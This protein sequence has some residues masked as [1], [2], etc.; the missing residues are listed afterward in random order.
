MFLLGMQQTIAKP[1]RVVGFGYWSGADVCVEFRPAPVDAGVTFVRSDLGPNARVA[2]RADLRT[3]V[4]RRT[5][6][7]CGDVQVDM[8]EHILAALAGMQVDNCE[9]WVD[10][11]EMPGCDGSAQVF[12]D[13]IRRVG[14]VR[15]GAT[16]RWLTIA[17]RIKLEEGECWI[18]ARPSRSN[19]LSIEFQLDYPRDSAIGRQTAKWTVTPDVFCREIAPSRTFLLASEAKLLVAQGLGGRVTTRD[20]L[21]FSEQGP[22]DNR[23][24]FHN[25]CARHKLLD[26]LGDLALTGCRVVGEL[27]AH[28]SGHRLNA[29]LARQLTQLYA[30]AAF[31]DTA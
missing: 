18:E 1:A 9:V 20:L 17:D 13:A 8:V 26:V 24:R 29:K 19:S 2:A 11:P 12:V 16:P 6:L 30:P 5:S 27:I 25:E 3:E 4:P 10:R 7:R 22:I 21:V 23:L 31:K 14:V 28:R 15:Q